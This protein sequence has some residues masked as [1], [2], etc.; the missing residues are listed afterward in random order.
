MSVAHNGPPTTQ[1][2]PVPDFDPQVK[3]PAS[4]LAASARA[5]QL[6]HESQG[7][8]PEGQQP[9]QPEQPVEQQPGTATVT[10]QQ[11]PPQQ[12][13]APQEDS[14]EHRYNSMKGRYD[15]ANDQL[16]NMSEQ[17]SNMQH[18]IAT[19][20]QPAPTPPELRAERLISAEEENDYGREFL[21]V[22]G[23]KAKEEF[24]PE[25]A[26]LR[27]ELARVNAKLDGVG[28]HLQ[29]NARQNMLAQMTARLP[30]WREINVDDGFK[31]WLSLPDPY[32]GAIRHELLKVAFERNNTPQVLA[33]FN[34][35]LAEEAATDPARR[36]PD[37]GRQAQ[38]P[39][40]TLAAP[41]R[42]KSSAA[43]APAE[44]PSFTRAQIAS[45]YAQVGAG[46]YRGRDA[47][48]DKLERQIFD[49]QRDGRIR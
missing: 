40:E 31:H 34:G 23:K 33:F 20:Q 37:Q 4:V 48:K 43:S 28:G 25:V 26:E 17:I 13:A 7:T 39:L 46:K 45:F 27:N 18:V 16:R 38:I 47:E 1:H 36:E 41:G 11:P 44:K 29:Q 42:A 8:Q 22:V 19:M 24:T 9:E 6:F 35:F 14:W 21:D 32:S 30:E 12:R 49:A 15:R 10:E 5:D 2:A 3:I